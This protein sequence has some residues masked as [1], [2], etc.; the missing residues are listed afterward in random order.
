VAEAHLV[1]QDQPG[2]GEQREGFPRPLRVPDE[3]ALLRGIFAAVDDPVDGD[4]LVLAEDG[5]P[6]LTVLHVEQDPVLERAQ[7]VGGLE[8]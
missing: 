8:E 4:A 7:E 1:L 6:R 2:G 5:F 3:A